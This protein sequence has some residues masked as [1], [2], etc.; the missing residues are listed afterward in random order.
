VRNAGNCESHAAGT[1]LSGCD[2]KPRKSLPRSDLRATCASVTCDLQMSPAGFEPTTY[3]L[4]VRMDNDARSCS[5][6]ETR[7]LR[8]G[9]ST[10]PNLTIGSIRF[11]T[12]SWSPSSRDDFMNAHCATDTEQANK[13]GPPF[14]PRSTWSTEWPRCS[15]PHANRGRCRTRTPHQ[16]PRKVMVKLG[17]VQQAVQSEGRMTSTGGSTGS[18]LR[19]YRESSLHSPRSRH[20]H[21]LP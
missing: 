20:V 18:N 17:T 9:R 16:T 6:R 4:K 7:M 11:R 10:S 19:L 13:R 2:Q 8:E 3:G 21:A 14:S 15:D 12:R 5:K 1:Q